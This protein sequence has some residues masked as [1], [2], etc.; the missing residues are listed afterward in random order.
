LNRLPHRRMHQALTNSFRESR[1]LFPRAEHLLRNQRV[2]DSERNNVTPVNRRIAE[3][4]EQLETVVA[5][6]H[7]PRGSPPFV[8]FGPCV[9][10]LR[11]NDN[12]IE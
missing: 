2:S 7:Q 3:D 6:V 1:I 11:I 10:H 8:V 4:L 9:I 5:I 12:D